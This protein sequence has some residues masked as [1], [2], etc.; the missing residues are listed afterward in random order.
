MADGNIHLGEALE[1]F[2][3]SPSALAGMRMELK[4]FVTLCG[5]ECPMFTINVSEAKEYLMEVKKPAERKKRAEAL[6]SFFEFAKENGWVLNNLAAGLIEKKE[7]KARKPITQ[8]PSNSKPEPIR[9]TEE[10]RLKI[11]S[12]IKELLRAK[13][14]VIKEVAAAREEGDLSENAGYHDA[15][16]RLGLIE[17]QIRQKEDIL[18]RANPLR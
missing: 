8:T 13:K 3:N 10:G 12:E 18:A 16:E 15:R 7:P 4:R 17:G 5:K 11:E 14:R 1:Q 2:F 9:I 6:E